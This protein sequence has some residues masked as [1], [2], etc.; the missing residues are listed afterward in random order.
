M[1]LDRFVAKMVQIM[2]IVVKIMDPVNS[3]VKMVQTIRT[4]A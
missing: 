4:V 1:D 2:L 3:A